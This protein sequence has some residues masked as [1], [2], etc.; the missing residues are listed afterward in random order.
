MAVKEGNI[1]HVEYT[2]TFDDGE[3]FDSSEGGEPLVFQV[4]ACQVIEGFEKAVLGKE[5]G[6]DIKIRLTP[7]QAYGEYDKEAVQDV[8]R[9]QFPKDQTPEPGMCLH[10]QTPDGDELSAW[11]KEVKDD[12]I[13]LDFNHPMAGKILN[14][15]MK[16]V[17]VEEGGEIKSHCGCDCDHCHEH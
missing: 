16:I 14:F 10:I 11:I 2:G 8:P 7:D 5:K 1:V 9:A 4:G 3:V 17:E 6:Q 12:A 15:K 13:T